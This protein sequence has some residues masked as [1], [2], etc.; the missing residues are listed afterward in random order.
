VKT[1]VSYRYTAR[2]Q[3]SLK[4]VSHQEKYRDTE[5]AE[6][7]QYGNILH[8]ALSHVICASDVGKATLRLIEEGMVRTEA[9]AILKQRLESVVRHPRLARYFE[10]GVR[11]LNEQE[12]FLKN[13]VILRPD[14]LV[15][16][17]EEA[18]I[19]D[20]KTGR[21]DEKHRNQIQAYREAI[22]AMGYVVKT[23][24]IVYISENLITPEFI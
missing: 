1:P 14:R 20:Y 4:L 22:E 21:T 23:A 10:P 9:S 24:I 11:V 13:G 15:F 12:I 5:Q 19:M 16:L 18:V 8:Y 7:L 2:D 6:A 17:K 3:I